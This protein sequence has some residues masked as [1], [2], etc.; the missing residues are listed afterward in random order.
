M[1]QVPVKLGLSQWVLDEEQ[2]NNISYSTIMWFLVLMKESINFSFILV[3][4]TIKLYWYLI[5]VELAVRN[6]NSIS[7]NVIEDKWLERR[8]F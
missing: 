4:D 2:H 6:G 8:S 5:H 1:N 3:I 7:M